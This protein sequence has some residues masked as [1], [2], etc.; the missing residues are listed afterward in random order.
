M[1]R[2][3]PVNRID[4]PRSVP[5]TKDGASPAN[6]MDAFITRV[7]L[8][9]RT[10]LQT[11]K[12]KGTSQRLQDQLREKLDNSDICML[13]S[14]SDP[15]PT[16]DEKG[17]YLV[18]DVG[19]SWLRVARV[20]L[21]GRPRGKKDATEIVRLWRFTIN[22]DVRL[23]PGMRFFDWMGRK[24]WE[25]LHEESSK[26]LRQRAAFHVMGLAWSFPLE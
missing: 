12:L 19:G 24:I 9:F 10:P 25:C 11:Q 20:R 17:E 18:A 16:G 21:H 14:Y 6:S 23:L 15:L 4:I 1:P 26:G 22:E 2:P 7:E 5:L 13:P 8:E 3:H